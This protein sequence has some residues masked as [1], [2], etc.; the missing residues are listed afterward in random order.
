M[1]REQLALLPRIPML[2]AI[3][4]IAA[5][6][7]IFW[8]YGGSRPLKDTGM[9]CLPGSFRTRALL[10]LLLL[11]LLLPLLLC[12]ATGSPCGRYRAALRP[13]DVMGAV[14][15]GCTTTAGPVT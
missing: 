3:K 15:R 11:L 7:E 14:M 13:E 6:T 5:G 4:D 1:K 8:D 12:C 9:Q 2:E 10:L